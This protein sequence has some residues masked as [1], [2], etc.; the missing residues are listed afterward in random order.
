M[1]NLRGYTVEQ[2]EQGI[3]Q[4]RSTGDLTSVMQLEGARDATIASQQKLTTYG[5]DKVAEFKKANELSTYEEVNGRVQAFGSGASLGFANDIQGMVSNLDM[6]GNVDY[7]MDGEGDDIPMFGNDGRLERFWD[8]S[9]ARTA[10]AAQE[11]AEFAEA[12]PGEA[13]LLEAAGAIM[14]F[15]A[16]ASSCGAMAVANAAG[17]GVK[18][19]AAGASAVAAADGAV[20]GV[21]T[22][23]AR[24]DEA[25][26]MAWH[27]AKTTL[28]GS[29]GGAILGAGIKGVSN[30]IAAN[31]Y[32]KDHVAGLKTVDDANY[33][34][35]E[36]QEAFIIARMDN[37]DKSVGDILN[38]VSKESE[39]AQRY[40]EQ[41]L[42]AALVAGST[43]PKVPTQA[44]QK[45]LDDHRARV[46]AKRTQGPEE[47]L[48]GK[49]QL[50]EERFRGGGAGNF[51]DYYVGA[52]NTRLRVM[53][54]K[55]GAAL[56]GRDARIAIKTS[57]RV[58]G[59]APLEVLNPK[60]LAKLGAGTKANG[61]MYKTMTRLYN[62]DDID[63]IT[64]L[65]KTHPDPEVSKAW[66]S[67]IKSKNE[68]D[69]EL[70]GVGF[71]REGGEALLPR[72]V[73]DPK[74]LKNHLGKETVAAFD[75]HLVAVANKMQKARG[76]VVRITS[77]AAARRLIGEAAEH[78]EL[79]K[80]V[81]AQRRGKAKGKVSQ[82]G[83][84]KARTVDDITEELSPFYADPLAAMTS[85]I[86]RVTE[87]V[88]DRAFFGGANGKQKLGSRE[89]VDVDLGIQQLLKDSGIEG[90]DPRYAQMTSL[91]E[92]LF[93]HG[94][95]S[96]SGFARHIKEVGLISALANP[97]AAAIQL[98]DLGVTALRTGGQNTAKALAKTLS[99]EVGMVNVDGIGM[100]NRVSAEFTAGRPM[101]A[102]AKTLDWG[103]ALSGFKNMDRFVKSTHIKA[104]VSGAKKTAAD[105]VAWNKQFGEAFPGAAGEKLRREMLDP[106]FGIN[107]SMDARVLMWSGLN[108]IQPLSTSS[109]PQGYHNHPTGR[110]FYTLQS[111]AL[112][113]L[114]LIR[115]SVVHEWQKG[116]KAQA[117]T[118]LASYMMITGASQY[119]INEVRKAA[120]SGWADPIDMQPEDLTSG[121]LWHIL[122][123]VS[124]GKG[125][126][127]NTERAFSGMG[128]GLGDMASSV[129]P[130]LGIYEAAATD[131]ANILTKDWDEDNMRFTDMASVRAIP[132]IGDSLY[133][134]FG[135]GYENRAEAYANKH[136]ESLSGG[137]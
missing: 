127:Y 119:G 53:H 1:S 11:A 72:V 37:P 16:G 29:A 95:V 48:A 47:F 132:V 50:D 64:A 90:G 56:D 100:A 17:G 125:S 112:K 134:L 102:V 15:G 63:G 111:F 126:K 108:D 24:F 106:N 35:D 79:A 89:E 55:I 121:M 34:I 84:T 32:I 103:L 42:K 14:T 101:G 82:L 99:R 7:D 81:L 70:G 98:A 104:F 22:L 4:A 80:F 51:V 105:P 45:T 113:Q 10:E 46:A 33:V 61:D 124:V 66:N 9:R 88:E 5:D 59:I 71:P 28:V 130:P 137:Y 43:K 96:T 122:S 69:A 27:I 120:F 73:K 60:G 39:L 76:E 87:N 83:T 65:L 19:A 49:K 129:I 75:M 114:D 2:Y 128:G 117:S 58:K 107:P 131:V 18:G 136:P 21:G 6:L 40:T 13:I 97:K 36:I 20:Y 25:T 93:R 41:E 68:M 26:D 74:G 86:R 67:W 116:N 110:M 44:V 78:E 135:S 30:K 85:H 23:D 57:D 8:G 92:S 123:T 94:K 133:M 62:N 3:A 91:L 118:A 52:V 115:R 54:P 109:L 12:K 77:P 38:I 31:K